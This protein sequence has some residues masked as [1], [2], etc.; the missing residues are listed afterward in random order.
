[1]LVDDGLLERENGR[2]ARS[3]SSP[4]WSVPASIEALLGARL[5]RLEA[6]S[7]TSWSARP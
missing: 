1:M 5:D 7:G 6:E 2:W 4:R 3:E